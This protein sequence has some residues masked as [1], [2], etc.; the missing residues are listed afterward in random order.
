VKAFQQALCAVVFAGMVASGIAAQTKH[1]RDFEIHDPDTVRWWH[2]TEAL[3]NDGMEG[4][5]T[6]TAAYQRAADYVAK[7]FTAAGLKPAGEK[8]TYFKPCRCT[9]WT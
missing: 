2:T 7:R 3:A 5:D 1:P 8:G 4:R 6:G 9:R